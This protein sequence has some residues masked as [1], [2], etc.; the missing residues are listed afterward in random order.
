MVSHGLSC[1]GWDVSADGGAAKC[2]V[3]ICVRANNVSG[4][5][6]SATT[7][8]VVWLQLTLS[9]L[10]VDALSSVPLIAKVFLVS[11]DV[12][13]REWMETLTK[14][15]NC[16]KLILGCGS[17]VLHILLHND[18]LGEWSFLLSLAMD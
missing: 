13:G 17:H 16:A 6:P 3:Q 11:V 10:A 15:P 7:E 2:S 18:G 14:V 1:L 12:V 4:T 8:I 9:R 5:V